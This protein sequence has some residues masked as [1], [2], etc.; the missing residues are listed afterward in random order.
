MNQI[1][2]YLNG[3][4]TEGQS[5]RGKT[6]YRSNINIIPVAH[7]RPNINPD[8]LCCTSLGAHYMG[9]SIRMYEDSPSVHLDFHSFYER[10]AF[11]NGPRPV[12]QHRTMMI[13]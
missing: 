12:A 1:N 5:K 11:V 8:R 6:S 9:K 2:I 10:K 13:T 3:N 7:V 4:R